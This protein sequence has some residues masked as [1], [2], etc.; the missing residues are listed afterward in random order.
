MRGKLLIAVGFIFCLV[1]GCGPDKKSQHDLDEPYN[2]EVMHISCD[3]SF[4]PV[5]DAQIGVYESQ[6]AGTKIIPHYKPE[7]ECL[8]DLVIDTIRMVIITRKISKNE[9]ELV[10]DSTASGAEQLVVARDVISVILHP[11]APDSF[12]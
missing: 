3:E 8:K 6:H 9:R 4:K 10:S 12:F 11:S 5:I 2:N 7:A 1:C